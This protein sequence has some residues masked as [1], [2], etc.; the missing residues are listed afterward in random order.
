MEA[1]IQISRYRPQSTPVATAWCV[2]ACRSSYAGEVAEIIRRTGGSVAMLVDNLA[3]PQP[4]AFGPV[5]TPAELSDR[6]YLGAVV[7][8]LITPGH[9]YTVL[10]Q[11]RSLGLANFPSLIDPTA[12]IASTAETGDGCVANVRTV[13]GA[14]ARIGRFVHLNRNTSVGHD[15]EL[16]D[17]VTLGPGC[18]LSGHVVVERG[19]FVGA[20][21]VIAPKVRIGANAVVGTGA[22]VT[23]DVAP[24]VVVI[25]NPARAVPGIMGGYGDPPGWVPEAEPLS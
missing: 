17:F 7:I 23:R 10:G 19:A 24:G 16:Q 25:G 14:S 13:V 21:A 15:V 9:R 18:V 11:A 3:V 5:V 8:P 1:A 2:F 12:I 20:G 6:P 4:S 22:V